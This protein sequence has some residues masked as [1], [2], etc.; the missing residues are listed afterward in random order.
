MTRVLVTGGAGYI[1]SVLIKELV[2]SG[3]DVTVLD[4]L[5]Y[6]KEGIDEYIKN[7]SIK[8]IVNDV[9]D[10]NVLKLIT[11]DIDY[12]IHLAAVVGQPLCD[13]IPV[14][15]RQINEFATKNLVDICKENGVKRFVFSSTCSNYGSTDEA[16]DGSSPLN[17]LGLYS[18]AKVNSEKYILE[19]KS[20]DFHPIVLRF[21]TAYGLSPRMRFDLLVS[22]F[23]RDALIDKKITVF[24]PQYW[25]PVIHVKDIVKS[26]LLVLKNI[27]EIVS[28]QI[29]NVGSNEQ[30]YKKIELAKIIQKY[31]PETEI[32]IIESCKD[33][34]NYRVSFDKISRM[35][36][37]T[38]K[39]TV[40]E[41]VSEILVEVKNK[42]LDPKKTEFSN[43]SKL[44][45]NIKVF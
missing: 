37:F 27:P 5:V 30:N 6:G 44:T 43:M 28:G 11:K 22:E 25:R 45:E 10:N 20:S 14:A 35:L 18:E 34:R 32:E 13:K 42:N 12:V 24:D 3:Y 9:R 31:V 33:P 38:T 23:L 39:I 41:G 36:G 2:K 29:F 16:V 40:E 1:G 19:S 4:S 26:C 21:A 17:P 8:L 15:A 7:N